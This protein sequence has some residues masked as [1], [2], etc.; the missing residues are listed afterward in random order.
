[1]HDGRVLTVFSAS[2]YCGRGTNRGAFIIFESDLGHTVQQYVAGPLE[3]TEPTGTAPSL[4]ELMRT[5]PR[6]YEFATAVS[7]GKIAPLRR[8]GSSRSQGASASF[9]GALPSDEAEDAEDEAAQQEAVRRMLVERICLH[10]DSLYFFW[11]TTDRG[12]AAGRAPAASATTSPGASVPA[13]PTGLITKIQ[14]ADGMRQVLNLDLPWLALAP[15]LVE[16]ESDGRISYARFLDRYHIAMRESDG[17][18]MESIIDRV[19]ERLFSACNS[20]ESAFAQ[21]DADGSGVVGACARGGVTVW[22]RWR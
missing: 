3:E 22:V 5:A 20:L 16:V 4:E 9:H 7:G 1:M 18:W 11:S 12:Q 19:S 15:L 14:W 8:V 17:A 2:R 13:A 10:K 21:L 6:Q